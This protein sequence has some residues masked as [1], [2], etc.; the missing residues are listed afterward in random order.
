MDKRLQKSFFWPRRF[1]H[2]DKSGADGAAQIILPSSA[3][4][5]FRFIGMRATFDPLICRDQFG[6]TLKSC[7]NAER[8]NCV[9]L[10][11]ICGSH[12]IYALTGGNTLFYYPSEIL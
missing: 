12:Q 1:T 4:V 2:P 6:C 10:W 3:K 5:C 8:W 9:R 7:C 11:R